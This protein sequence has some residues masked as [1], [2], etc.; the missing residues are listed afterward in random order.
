MMD[1]TNLPPESWEY[2]YLEEIGS[3]LPD[4]HIVA[5]AW[6]SYWHSAKNQ[7]EM[8]DL[9]LP[10]G[11][12][13]ETVLIVVS[14]E[15]ER[16]LPPLEVKAIFK[17]YITKQSFNQFPIPLGC[18]R[19]F[20]EL[21][22]RPIN[23]R[24]VDVSFVGRLYSHRR[25]LITSLRSHP[26]LRKFNTVFSDGGHTAFEYSSLLNDTK[27][28]LCL[29]GNYSP[30]TMRYFESLRMGC[31]TISPNYPKTV[32]YEQSPGIVLDDMTDADAVVARIQALLNSAATLAHLSQ[33]SMDGWKARYHPQAV[34]QYIRQTLLR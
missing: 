17:H 33:R 8:R 32:I 13:K 23:D 22:A 29:G 16:Q 15:Y 26:G 19:S 3:H 11:L 1:L 14:D 4:L 27:I 24:S 2:S 31:V 25:N 20:C 21:A 10:R 18:R 30:E 28:S 5:V 6:Q 12:T 9:I 34:A 7:P